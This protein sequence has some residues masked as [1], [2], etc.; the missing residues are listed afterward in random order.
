MMACALGSWPMA[1]L[2]LATSQSKMREYSVLARESR[3]SVEARA[4]R[5][6]TMAPARSGHWV[7]LAGGAVWPH[8]QTGLEDSCSAPPGQRSSL[9]TGQQQAHR[10]ASAGCAW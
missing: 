3:L 7:S 1:E 8:L 2:I 9:P 4:S 5:G 10:R 6:L